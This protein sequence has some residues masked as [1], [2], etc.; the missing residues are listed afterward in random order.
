M[1]IKDYVDINFNDLSKI[2]NT[3]HFDFIDKNLDNVSS[4]KINTYPFLEEHLTPKVYFDNTVSD[5]ISYVDKLHEIKRR[6]QNLSSVFNDQDNEFEENKST[7][8]DSITV[9]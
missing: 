8:L 2:K 1:P 3:D 6:R 9:N 7:S 4:I 5:I